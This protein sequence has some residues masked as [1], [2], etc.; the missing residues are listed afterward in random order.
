[1]PIPNPQLRFIRRE[2]VE[3]IGSRL[4]IFKVRL[5]TRRFTDAVHAALSSPLKK[6]K[7]EYMFVTLPACIVEH[8]FPKE[9]WC[10]VDRA[11]VSLLSPNR[12]VSLMSSLYI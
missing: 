3:T 7:Q 9:M 2:V 6:N 4:V 10:N 8:V 5:D 12:M 1:M 11:R